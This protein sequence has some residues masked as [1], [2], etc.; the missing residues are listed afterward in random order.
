MRRYAYYEVKIESIVNLLN[1]Q[2]SLPICK[3]CEIEMNE[4]IEKWIAL[5]DSICNI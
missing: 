4:L 5:C 1:M 3:R 2:Q